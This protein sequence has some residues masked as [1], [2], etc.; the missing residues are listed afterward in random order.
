MK[1]NKI[2]RCLRAH[3]ALK[4]STQLNLAVDKKSIFT[5]ASRKVLIEFLWIIYGLIFMQ[6]AR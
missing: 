4:D 6:E 2:L 1:V 3:F 5:R